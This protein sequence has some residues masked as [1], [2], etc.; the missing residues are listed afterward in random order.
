MIM[1]LLT[2]TIMSPKIWISNQKHLTISI[3]ESKDQFGCGLLDVWLLYGFSLQI[4]TSN[5][6]QMQ[7]TGDIKDP[8][9]ITTQMIAIHLMTN[10]LKCLN[11]KLIDN[12]MI[13][14]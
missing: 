4:Y 9:H 12:Y 14:V 5:T 8:H 7:I 1:I 2:S 3:L 6:G 10:T 11:Q 13:Q